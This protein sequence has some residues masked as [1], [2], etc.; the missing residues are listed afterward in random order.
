MPPLSDNQWG[1][2]R[3]KSTESSLLLITHEWHS[4]IDHHKDVMCV[5]FDFQKAFDTVPHHRLM[6]RLADIG[7]HPLLM[8]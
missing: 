8:S 5:F 4:F 2:H 6:D 7:I 1:F 3:G